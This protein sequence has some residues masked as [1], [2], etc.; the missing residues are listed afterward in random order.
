MRLIAKSIICSLALLYTPLHDSNIELECLT[1]NVYFEARGEATEGKLAVAL[2]T[3][4]RATNSICDAV[5]AKKQF[6][7]TA[8]YSKIPRDTKAWQASE[9]AA[10]TAYYGKYSFTATHY[11]NTKVHP[12]WKLKKVAKIGNHIFYEKL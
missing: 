9:V 6:S 10:Y 3:L 1:R 5:Y 2:V 11:H 12:K 8:H 7:W 4:N